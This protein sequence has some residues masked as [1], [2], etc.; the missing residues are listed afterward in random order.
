[1][2][3]TVNGWRRTKAQRHK[4]EDER[5]T[6]DSLFDCALVRDPKRFNKRLCSKAQTSERKKFGYRNWLYFVALWLG[7]GIQ[8]P[9][10]AECVRNPLFRGCSARAFSF[11]PLAPGA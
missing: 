7:C 6:W 10:I 9:G 11:E 4:E 2:V 5:D 8:K 3:E 1:M